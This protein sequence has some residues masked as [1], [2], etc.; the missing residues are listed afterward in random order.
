[1]PEYRGRTSPNSASPFVELV[2]LLQGPTLHSS[3]WGRLSTL[4]LQVRK[5]RHGQTKPMLECMC[6]YAAG[7]R[8]SVRNLLLPLVDPRLKT[9]RAVARLLNQF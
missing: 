8:A 5:P 7:L 6:S 2:S 9:Q 3:P 4:I 1:M